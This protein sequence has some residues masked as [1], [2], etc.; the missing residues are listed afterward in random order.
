[1]SGYGYSDGYGDYDEDPEDD[2]YEEV[3]GEL[4]AATA[5]AVLLLVGGEELWF[6]RSLLEDDAAVDEAAPGDEV[7]LAV[8]AWKLRELGL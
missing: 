2:G 5:K 8:A 4:R 3:T 1:M 6:P 7:A